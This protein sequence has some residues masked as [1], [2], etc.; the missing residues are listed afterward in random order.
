MNEMLDVIGKNL[1]Q[2]VARSPTKREQVTQVL[3][4]QSLDN[5]SKMGCGL[6]DATN[7]TFQSNNF[8]VS[9]MKMQNN[10]FMTQEN[11]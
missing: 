7:S 4:Q 10:P 5:S 1:A 6:G 8:K 9:A 3:S 2:D 11:F